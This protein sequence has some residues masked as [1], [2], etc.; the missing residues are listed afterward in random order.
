MSKDGEYLMGGSSF[1]SLLA[2]EDA[3]ARC[4]LDIP[5]LHPLKAA[6]LGCSGE[7]GVL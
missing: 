3:G 7:L 5:R 6:K 2:L 4:Y 1:L